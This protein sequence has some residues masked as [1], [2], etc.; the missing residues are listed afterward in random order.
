MHGY[1]Q[2]CDVL[3]IWNKTIFIQHRA[4]TCLSKSLASIRQRELY[5]MGNTGLLRHEAEMTILQPQLGETRCQ[6]LRNSLFFWTL[7]KQAPF[8]VPTRKEAPTGNAPMGAT[9]HKTGIS[10]FPQ[11]GGNQTS[12]ASGVVFNPTLGGEG[13][14]TPH[15]NDSLIAS[16]SSLVGG[17]FHSFRRDWQP[18]IH[19]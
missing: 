12:E 13:V 9:P 19:S 3:D 17:Q 14:N 15:H 8:V 18:N 5:T 4:L 2:A 11:P 10:R 6:Q 16:L 1:D 7:S